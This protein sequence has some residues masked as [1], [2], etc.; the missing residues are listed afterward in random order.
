MSPSL[1]IRTSGGAGSS[2]TKVNM[3]GKAAAEFTFINL[4]EPKQSK[5]KKFKRIIRSNA[6][7][8]YRQLEKR[9]AAT[10]RVQNASVGTDNIEDALPPTAAGG[11][12]GWEAQQDSAQAVAQDM[13]EPGIKSLGLP[14]AGASNHSDR[15]ACGH[16]DCNGVDCVKRLAKQGPRLRPQNLIGNSI[17]DPFDVYPSSGSARYDSYVLNHCKPHT[18]P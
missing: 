18:C 16:I 12:D 2:K 4:S 15:F 7:R 10:K 1:V 11:L 13:S 6:M 17:C 3:G 14:S 5:D 8:T 9:K